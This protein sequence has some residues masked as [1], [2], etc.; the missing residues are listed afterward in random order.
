MIAGRSAPVQLLGITAA[1]LLADC[2]GAAE[3]GHRRFRYAEA[4]AVPAAVA[5][6]DELAALLA[7]HAFRNGLAYRDSTPQAQR[8]SNGRRTLALTL[9]RPLTSGRLWAETEARAQGNGAVLVTFAEPLD[10]GI[11][12]D[13]ARGRA[14]MLAEL[15]R[16]WPATATIALLPGG[17]LPARWR[18]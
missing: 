16:R 14:A 4:I 1:L 15:R 11:A 8:Q 5:D 7:G 17:G 10:P 9:E 2:S 6:R 13:A 3:P 18:R 12:G